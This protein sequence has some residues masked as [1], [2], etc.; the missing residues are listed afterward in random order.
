MTGDGHPNQ[1]LSAG[2]GLGL[3]F[4]GFGLGLGVQGVLGGSWDLVSKV[5]STLIGAISNYK[6]SYHNYNPRGEGFRV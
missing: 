1:C 2:L 4:G 6:Y 3:G 5:I